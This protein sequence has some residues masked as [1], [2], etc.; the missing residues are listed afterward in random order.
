MPKIL[1][2]EDDKELSKIMQLELKHEGFE[3]YP[4]YDGR[5]A[6]D[7]VA[8]KQQTEPYD[9][10][11]LDVMLPKVSGLEVLRKLRAQAETT[12]QKSVPII[13]VT[14]RGETIDKVD[15][16]N[17]GADDYITKPFK[18]EELLA[19]INAVLR[20]T[21]AVVTKPAELKNG[22]IVMTIDEMKVVKT[23]KKKATPPEQ[24]ELSK[25]EFFLLKLFL[26]NQEKI[27]SR[28]QIIQ[29][30]WGEDYYIEENSVDV[31][32]RHLRKKFGEDII[33]T[34]RGMGYI[35]K[36]QTE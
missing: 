36:T 31:Y 3:V 17:S 13:L 19:R 8:A 22:T 24:I 15:G 35:M 9:L 16:L 26:E 25:N 30:V 18:I 33:K 29:L 1:L 34:V 11:L 4:V 7:E 23:D 32:V 14:A 6:L 10:M 27:L 21:Q 12:N 2:V 20:R 28:D 5:Q